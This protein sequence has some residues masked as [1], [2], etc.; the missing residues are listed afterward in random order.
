MKGA[1]LDAVSVAIA[2]E[3]PIA[4]VKVRAKIPSPIDNFLFIISVVI[5]LVMNAP[6]F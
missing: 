6:T 4:S 3:I 5:K 1:P 2:E